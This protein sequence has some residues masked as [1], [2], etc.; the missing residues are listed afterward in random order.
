MYLD[1]L[2]A[3]NCASATCNLRGRCVEINILIPFL[4]VGLNGN[5]PLLNALRVNS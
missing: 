3:F 1:V 2:P 4:C 5:I